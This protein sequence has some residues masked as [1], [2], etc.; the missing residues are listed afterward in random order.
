VSSN[1]I[2]SANYHGFLRLFGQSWDLFSQLSPIDEPV[3]GERGRSEVIA[4]WANRII[5]T[6]KMVLTLS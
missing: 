3:D 2:P 6:I 4:R 5:M 1:L